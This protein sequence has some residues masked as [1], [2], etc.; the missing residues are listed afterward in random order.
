MVAESLLRLAWRP[1][2]FH[3]PQAMVTAHGALA[4]RHGWLLRLEAADGG[5]GWGEALALEPDQGAMA[6]GLA[7]AIRLRFWILSL[8]IAQTCSS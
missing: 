1:F 2:Q 8:D 5:L 7:G 4:Q 6:S 3:L